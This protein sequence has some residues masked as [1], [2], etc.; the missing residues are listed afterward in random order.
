MKLQLQYND[1]DVYSAHNEGKSNVTERFI[2][3]KIEKLMTSMSKKCILINQTIQYL[4]KT[5][6]IIAQ[7]Q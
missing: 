4:N 7:S 1:L 3:N 6:H 2:K 5:M